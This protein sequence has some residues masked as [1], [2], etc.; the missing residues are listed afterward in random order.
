MSVAS[1]AALKA[2]LRN[3][4][5][6]AFLEPDGKNVAKVRPWVLVE[7]M[8]FDRMAALR[9][10]VRAA[11]NTSSF[12]PGLVAYSLYLDTENGHHLA[13][14]RD[15][16]PGHFNTQ[17]QADVH[18]CMLFAQSYDADAA[19]ARAREWAGMQMAWITRQP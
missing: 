7:L 11:F 1:A 18:T 8:D 2:Y 15:G 10:D 3:N 13:V 19:Q 17:A 6:E 9:A 14:V 12:P 16:R 5:A 4:G